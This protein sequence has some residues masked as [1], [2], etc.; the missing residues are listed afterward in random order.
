MV[1]YPVSGSPIER[2]F[3]MA[4]CNNCGKSTTFGH[5]R[6]FSQRATNRSFKA[7]LQKV[8][9]LEKGRLVRKTLCT[10]CIKTYGK[11]AA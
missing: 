9:L 2:D 5:S 7:N 10:R 6:S 4:K 3:L 8:T 11:S 1:E